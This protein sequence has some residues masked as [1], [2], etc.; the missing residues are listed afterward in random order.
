MLQRSKFDKDRWSFRSIAVV[1]VTSFVASAVFAGSLVLGSEAATA[2]PVA[3]SSE[4]L[5]A[6]DEPSAASLAEAQG[7]SV[8]VES[9]TTETSQ[10][11]AQPDGTMTMTS[12]SV[13]VRVRQGDVWV[14]TNLDLEDQQ[15]W[16][17]P[18]VAASQ[19]RF[20]DGGSDVLA[21]IQTPSGE[22]MSEIW[23]KG[24]LPAPQ[25]EGSSATYAAVLPG[26][27]LRLT[28]TPAG[29]SE[30]LI[31]KT[32]AAGQSDDL[33]QLEL[34]MDGATVSDSASDGVAAAAPDGSTVAASAPT[35]WDSSTASSGPE[36][37]G[38]VSNPR[39]LD[40]T[41]DGSTV[42]L[43]VG[44]I[45]DQDNSLTYPLFVD[46]DWSS[47]AQSYWFTDRQ[48]PDQSYLNGQY[49][50][51]Y[52]SVGY[53]T[54][55]DGSYMS[56]A[57]WQFGV[58]ALEG[59]TIIDAQFSATENFSSCDTTAVQLWRFGVATP[60]F[61]WNQE[62]AQWRQQLDSKAL[63]NGSSCKA[64]GAI[65]MDATDGV[66]Y[67]AKSKTATIQL[68]LRSANESNS[69]TR[70]HFAQAA[71][72][73]VSYDSPPSTPTG[74]AFTTPSRACGA[75]VA[76]AAYM[77]G[78]QQISIQ[79]TPDDPDA[80]QNVLVRFSFYHASDT[81]TAYKT[82]ETKLGAQGT[83]QTLQVAAN[84]F[85]PGDYL[86]RAQTNDARDLSTA[87][88]A[89][90]F[91][92]K[93]THPSLPVVTAAAGN[94]QVGHALTATIT[95]AANDS[96]GKPN[97]IRGFAYWWQS[98][99]A[100][101]APPPAPTTINTTTSY[102]DC[103]FIDGV[104]TNVCATSNKSTVTVAPLDDV[105]T[106]WVAAYDRAGNVSLGPIDPTGNNSPPGTAAVSPLQINA[107]ADPNVDLTQGHFWEMDNVSSPYPTSVAD[108]NTT[109]PLP[110]SVGTRLQNTAAD[111]YKGAPVLA[112]TGASS[113]GIIKTASR[114][115]D[116]TKAFSVSAWI[117]PASTS[118]YQTVLSEK[119]AT[120]SAFYLQIK[121][122]YPRFCVKGQSAAAES[123][124][125]DTNV[126]TTNT[127]IFVTGIWD[128]VNGQIRLLIGP[129]TAPRGSDAYTPPDKEVSASGTI[130]VGSAFSNGALSDYFDG[131]IF[132]PSAFPGVL[133]KTEL[134]ALSLD[135]LSQLQP[136]N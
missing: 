79:A 25:L 36:G 129:D 113:D 37:P 66:A 41:A 49:S 94:Y 108:A 27:D 16:I 33:A 30:V 100:T 136:S 38:G 18:E 105:S 111:N 97:Q 99:A 64:P 73:T 57:F 69:Q 48:F 3:S 89:C 93:N 77:N 116:T 67:I 2:S 106:L 21:Q 56:R 130:Q 35:W 115:L 13:P 51:G 23:P 87:S 50:A 88:A 78:T 42:T 85:P 122:G 98:G 86:L 70:K 5:T 132:D 128:P 95:E 7:Q 117:K 135:S 82:A 46:P 126:M 75:S 101:S 32:K 24:P 127:W 60:G 19:V 58:A 17:Q 15:G 63:T 71:K 102:H 9:E 107:K 120:N 52:Q 10:V 59:K 84:T 34:D 61:S 31:V 29:M 76:G 62:P 6:P 125:A 55:A 109:T 118:G 40:H 112:L 4:P 26:V 119:G 68:G 80:G 74:V 53:G 45:A 72:L 54:D 47:G 131:D 28:A 83:A 8:A 1:A 114:A 124:A 104:V 22:W 20:A 134:S 133:D 110:L 103:D 65:G 43:D 96:S 91:S 81:D 44:S 39:P 12:E 11:L 123:C 90:Y 121:S 92:I 14:P